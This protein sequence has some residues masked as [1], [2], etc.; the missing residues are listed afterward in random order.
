[1]D[2]VAA[3]ILGASPSL[4]PEV[5]QTRPGVIRTDYFEGANADD[6]VVFESRPTTIDFNDALLILTP[7][8]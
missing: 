1:L 7:D 4:A 5:A 8:E 2:T 3:V 6:D